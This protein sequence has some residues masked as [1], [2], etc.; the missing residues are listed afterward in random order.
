VSCRWPHIYALNVDTNTF[1]LNGNSLATVATSGNY[2][3][4]TNKPVIPAQGVHLVSGS[5]QGPTAA[6]TGTGS[7]IAL[8]SATVPAGTF[9][10]G[11][12][13]KCRAFFHHS[14][15][16]ANVTMQWKLGGTTW[17]YPNT[18]STGNSP[19]C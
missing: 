11:T 1:T 3:D 10:A 9:A 15:G 18:F 8:Y 16:S 4:L 13:L 14:T 5:M 19:G 17:N 2:N 7:Q 6:I 12:G